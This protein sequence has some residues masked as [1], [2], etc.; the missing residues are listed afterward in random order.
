MFYLSD[1]VTLVSKDFV[2]L[3]FTETEEEL[4]KIKGYF[5]LLKERK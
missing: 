5:C 3:M 1:R 2:R 4:T